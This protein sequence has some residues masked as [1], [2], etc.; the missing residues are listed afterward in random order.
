MTTHLTIPLSQD[1]R[2]AI[3]VAAALAGLSTSAWVRK[4]LE[5]ATRTTD[6]P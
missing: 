2:E 4:I 3:R 1:L 5:A 6:R